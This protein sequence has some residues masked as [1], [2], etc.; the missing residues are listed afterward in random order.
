MTDNHIFGSVCLVI[1]NI[2]ACKKLPRKF[3][4]TKSSLAHIYLP[5]CL[6]DRKR[7]L[8]EDPTSYKKINVFFHFS[9][10]SK[11]S[12]IMILQLDN[13]VMYA[14][15]IDTVEYYSWEGYNMPFF[16]LRAR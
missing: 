3:S 16:T 8:Q 9:L 7:V 15:R 5:Y 10:K 1:I 13:K 11:G 14:I 12:K 4:K 6:P 2:H